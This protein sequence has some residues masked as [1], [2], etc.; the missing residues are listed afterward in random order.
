MTLIAE[1]RCWQ[2]MQCDPETRC[3]AKE[4]QAEECWEIIG[5]HDP[6]AFNICRDCLVYVAK[7]K[8]SSLTPEEVIEILNKKGLCRAAE[9]LK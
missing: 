5:S 1:W 7:K 9:I 8:D 3:P 2:I 6:C 4:N